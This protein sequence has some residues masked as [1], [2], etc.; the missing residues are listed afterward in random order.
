MESFH[1]IHHLPVRRRNRSE[2]LFLPIYDA[3]LWSHLQHISDDPR[4]LSHSILPYL[5]VWQAVRWK[6]DPAIAIEFIL[7]YFCIEHFVNFQTEF[8]A[9]KYLS[10]NHLHIHAQCLWNHK[11]IRKNDGSI[12]IK[13][14]QW[15]HGHF[16][17]QLW[18]TANGEE[19][20]LFSHFL[21]IL[22]K[23]Y[24]CFFFNFFYI[25]MVSS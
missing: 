3:S 8:S 19:I 4:L 2:A 10:G 7:I 13:P 20:I 22:K 1:L 24:F 21:I 14:S 17:G 18:R 11:N 12:K 23:I 9:L 5:T 15:L 6:Q 25:K 16:A